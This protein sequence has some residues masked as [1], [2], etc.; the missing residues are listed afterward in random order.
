MSKI[1]IKDLIKLNNGYADSLSP[2]IYR[3]IK[4]YIQD[5]RE[6]ISNNDDEA[7][8][9]SGVLDKEIEVEEDLYTNTLYLKK[10]EKD[11]AY[12]QFELKKLEYKINLLKK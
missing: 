7:M 6:F 3:F 5:W 10:L 8:K 4:D 11:K 1:L 2:H 12:L 9:L